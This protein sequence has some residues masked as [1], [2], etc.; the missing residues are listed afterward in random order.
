MD[1]DATMKRLMSLLSTFRRQFKGAPTTTVCAPGRINLLGGHT[2]YNEGFVLPIAIDLNVLFAVRPRPDDRV[3]VHSMNMR[4][5][6]RFSLRH[7]NTHNTA[8]WGL[9]LQGVA[10]AL[11]QAGYTLHGLEGV[12]H[13]TVPVGSG[14]SSSAALELALAWAWKVLDDLP[15]SRAEL[16]RL[17]Q[18][19]ES[20]FVGVPCGIMD[21]YVAAL[22]R[23]AHAL[24][25]DC[26]DLSY[27]LWPIP[28][29]VRIVACDINVRRA[30]ASSEYAVRRRQC[31]EAVTR[32]QVALPHIRA[33][34]DV[35]PE[36]LERHRDLLDDVLYR[37]ARHVVT[38]NARVQQALEA[39]SNGDLETLGRL[40]N[41]AHISLRDDYEVSSPELDA[42][43]EAANEVSGCYGA[44]LTGAGFGGN[45]VALVDK[46]ALSTF[47]KHVSERYHERTGKQATLRPVQAENGVTTL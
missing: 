43:W 31:E 26:R 33:L 30:L 36:V 45:V 15:I 42:M 23:K 22:G 25:I 46:R 18:K 14:L 38:E 27:S 41:E 10:W 29:Q 1:L 16:A 47:L 28:R 19:A 17:A 37:R 13:S 11:Q 9:Y 12:L 20:E 24:C 2:D 5:T 8:R 44:R 32:L 35:S 4:Q 39:L 3:I 34:R 7:L 21:Q 40:M 6:V